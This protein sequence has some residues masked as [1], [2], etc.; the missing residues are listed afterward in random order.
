MVFGGYS[1]GREHRGGTPASR[2]GNPR[3][4]RRAVS[5]LSETEAGEPESSTFFAESVVGRLRHS[6]RSVRRVIQDSASRALPT[7]LV[8]HAHAGC[9]RTHAFWRRLIDPTPFSSQQVG[10]RPLCLRSD[11]RVS[12]VAI[13]GGRNGRLYG[14]SS[15]TV[16]ARDRRWWLILQ[17]FAQEARDD[18]SSR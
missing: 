12:R 5:D 14:G 8:V 13:A 7:R 17:P 6:R 18:P 1:R 2:R 16:D 3:W 9:A 4:G 15:T 10:L 11:S